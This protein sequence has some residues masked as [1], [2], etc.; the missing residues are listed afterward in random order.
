[1]LNHRF[2]KKS[3]ISPIQILSLPNSNLTPIFSNGQ[4]KKYLKGKFYPK[5]FVALEN[6]PIV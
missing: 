4:Y 5:F 1:M 2:L 6:I 3:T